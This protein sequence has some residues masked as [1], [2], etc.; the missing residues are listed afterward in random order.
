LPTGAQVFNKFSTCP[1]AQPPGKFMA[2]GEE[3]ATSLRAKKS[4][5]CDL[6]EIVGESVRSSVD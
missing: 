1:K 4:S 2:G 3:A 5:C 6:L